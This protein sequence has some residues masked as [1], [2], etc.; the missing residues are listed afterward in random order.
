MKT[1][2][3]FLIFIFYLSNIA[4]ASRSDEWRSDGEKHANTHA[5][6]TFGYI[7]APLGNIVLLKGKE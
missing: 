1:L 4:Y 3:L 7:T 5:I 6:V 2:L